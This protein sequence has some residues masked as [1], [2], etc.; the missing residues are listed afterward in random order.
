VELDKTYKLIL[1]ERKK[2]QICYESVEEISPFTVLG[3]TKSFE[4]NA[5]IFNS[6]CTYAVSHKKQ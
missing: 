6:C 2:I 4:G 1:I 5:D 3:F